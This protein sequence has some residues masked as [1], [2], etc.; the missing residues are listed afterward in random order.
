MRAYQLIDN[1]LAEHAQWG[2]RAARDR[3]AAI[4]EMGDVSV[5]LSASHAAAPAAASRATLGSRSRS[6][7][8]RAAH[9]HISPNSTCPSARL[10]IV[11][12]GCLRSWPTLAAHI[13]ARDIDREVQRT[14]EGQPA[15]RGKGKNLAMHA[16]SW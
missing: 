1:R 4:I 3:V 9:R 10:S 8:R 15:E 16:P 2:S 14:R 11:R 5:D 6:G 7:W 12:K 13:L